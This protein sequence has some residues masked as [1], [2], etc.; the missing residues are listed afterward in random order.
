MKNYQLT[1]VVLGV[2]LM[3]GMTSAG[4]T[5]THGGHSVKC[6]GQPE[7]TLDFYNASLPT[8]GAPKPNIVDVSVLSIDQV[9]QLFKDRLL[10]TAIN[11]DFSNALNSIHSIDEWPLADLKW[12]N[13][14][15]KP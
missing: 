13:D 12:V 4:E 2:I 11:E 3:A 5:G 10:A 7:V 1:V 15:D 9:V 14:A 6:N 8:L